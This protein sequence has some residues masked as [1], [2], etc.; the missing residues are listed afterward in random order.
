MTVAQIFTVIDFEMPK[1]KL[2]LY[3]DA[4]LMELLSCFLSSTWPVR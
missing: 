4:N 3:K 2:F 1:I